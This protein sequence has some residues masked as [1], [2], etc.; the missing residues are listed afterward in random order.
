VAMVF[1]SY[2]LYPHM[3]VKENLA[4]PLKMAR[5]P[6]A[7]AE[8][9]VNEAAR[10]LGIADLLDRK[11]RTLSGG[12]MQRVAVG[13]AIVRHPKVF[14]FDEPLSNLDA[15]MRLTMRAEI[16]RLHKELG[17]TMIHVT[18]DQAEAMTLGSR[19]AVLEGGRLL[20][21]APPLEV[22]E[23]P[24][25]R[26]VAGFIGSPPMNFLGDVGIRPHDVE[27]AEDGPVEGR[28]ELVEAM[29]PETWVHLRVDGERILAVTKE[30]PAGD[31][32]RLRFPDQKVHRFD[33]EGK[34]CEG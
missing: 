8:A 9:R 14:L 30:P 26:F 1:Q 25:D 15:K 17:T 19:I 10:I 2:A 3:T 23:R 12:Q 16:S 27:V 29:G 31:V 28:V 7:E 11:P 24:A 32:L 13:R 5:T 34:R 20:Q 22:Y 18:H 33:R 21:A 6:R 4:F